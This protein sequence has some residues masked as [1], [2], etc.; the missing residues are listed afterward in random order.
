MHKLILENH[1][2][3]VYNQIRARRYQ[4]ERESGDE[5]ET[6]WHTGACVAPFCV[7]CIR[8][9]AELPDTTSENA[10]AGV[11]RRICGERSALIQAGR[12]LQPILTQG[13]I[14][15][16]QDAFGMLRRLR[17]LLDFA[18]VLLF[19]VWQCPLKRRR[20]RSHS[21]SKKQ[22]LIHYIQC[23]DLP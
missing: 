9:R 4:R 7:L 12:E 19:L 2:R 1:P 6:V 14:R 17:L 3:S 8:R 15:R 22:K 21:R 13:E 5:S 11:F 20:S 23:T 18:Y 10:V 16:G